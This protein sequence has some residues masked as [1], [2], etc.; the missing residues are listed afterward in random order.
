MVEKK[1]MSSEERQLHQDF[2]HQQRPSL[3]VTQLLRYLARVRLNVHSFFKGQDC[4]GG[5][6]CSAEPIP[7]DFQADPRILPGAR[8]VN[9]DS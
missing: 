3:G 8:E 2:H 1:K 5:A 9:E 7:P 6:L 4:C